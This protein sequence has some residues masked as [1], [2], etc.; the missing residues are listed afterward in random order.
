M[1]IVRGR[2]NKEIEIALICLELYDTVKGSRELKA[3]T[4]R[5]VVSMQGL[6]YSTGE[7]FPRSVTELSMQIKKADRQL[8]STLKTVMESVRGN[9]NSL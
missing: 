1:Y 9:C 8:I 3:E 4:S 6:H 5:D 2:A 7:Q